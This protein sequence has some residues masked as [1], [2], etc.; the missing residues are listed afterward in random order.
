[1]KHALIALPLMLGLAA[2]SSKNEPDEGT[3]VSIDATSESGKKV[4][5]SADGKSGNVGFKLPGFDVN[6]RLPK[7]LLDDSNF[8]IDGVKL[9]PGS[10]VDSVNITADKQAAKGD[11]ADVR[12][13]FT[14]PA[15]PAKVGGWF[16]EQFGKQ[17]VK[18]TGDATQLA[19]TTREGET[20]AIE[21]AEKDGKTA[22]TVVIR[23]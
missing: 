3:S 8:D 1:M 14:S 12:I 4:E 21:L 2:C 9:Y 17:S 7:K 11:R 18:L 15:E 19:G 6:M 22:G 13:A 16:K 10:T 5:I 20:F 23:K